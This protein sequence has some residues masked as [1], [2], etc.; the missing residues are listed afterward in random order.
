MASSADSP[1]AASRRLGRLLS[2]TEARLVAD[3]LEAGETTTAALGYVDP[4]ERPAVRDLVAA[5]GLGQDPAALATLMRAIEGAC[6]APGSTS[7]I[8]TLPGHAAQ[9]SALTSSV[10]KLV[11]SAT[12]SVVCS[13]YNFERTSGL[14]QALRDVARRPGVMVRIYIDGTVN[15]DAKELAAWLRPATVLRSGT[16][17]GKPVRNHAKFVSVDHRW[18]L[19]SSAN[20]SWSA[21]HGNVEVGVRIDDQHL[22]DSVE[23]EIRRAE[24]DL[25]EVVSST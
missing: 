25:Y 1:A 13:T 22:A 21:E 5:T 15:D 7:A 16:F 19:V 23:R 18:L 2:G 3:C 14:W 11:L 8:W 17:G 12:R 24:D 4:V 9:S 10:D 6:A 20:F